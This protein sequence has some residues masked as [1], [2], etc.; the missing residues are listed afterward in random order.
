MSHCGN[1]R[2]L[3]QQWALWF[4]QEDKLQRC[5]TV[6][7]YSSSADGNMEDEEARELAAKNRTVMHVWFGWIG[8]ILRFGEL[9]TM[10]I[11]KTGGH[12][13]LTG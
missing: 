7:L 8:V 13:I 10:R 6:I 2:T 9:G 1:V 5:G 12:F 4:R 11:P 3:F